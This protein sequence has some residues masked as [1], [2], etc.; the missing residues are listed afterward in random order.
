MSHEYIRK[1]LKDYHN[2]QKV[3]PANG[4]SY[5]KLT[6]D[7]EAALI[8]HLE[9]NNYVYARDIGLYIERQYGVIYTLAGVIKLLHRLGFSYKKPKLI[10][11]KI[12]LVKQEE[13]KLQ[14]S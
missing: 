12:D 3:K 4:G 9:E 10:P 13:F 7:Q 2:D 14:Y 1:H 6:V 8:E 5:S 11:G